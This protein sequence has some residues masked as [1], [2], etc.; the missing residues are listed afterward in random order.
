MRYR[1]VEY[2]FSVR[3]VNVRDGGGDFGHAFK[4]LHKTS[5]VTASFARYL[6]GHSLAFFT[7]P[8]QSPLVL[9]AQIISWSPRSR[10]H[11]QKSLHQQRRRHRPSQRP[12]PPSPARSQSHVVFDSPFFNFKV[13][14]NWSL[15]SSTSYR[16]DFS[17]LSG[18]DHRAVPGWMNANVWVCG[19][20]E[21]Y[22]RR[23]HSTSAAA[24]SQ[25]LE[26]NHG[27]GRG[28]YYMTYLDLTQGSELQT[29]GVF[30]L[31]RVFLGNTNIADHW[32]DLQRMTGQY[33]S[34]IIKNGERKAGG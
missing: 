2:D 27:L 16:P 4:T 14:S 17:S 13:R 3:H 33:H 26:S 21:Y 25:L 19:P 22:L 20:S 24:S 32:C 23:K 10:Q 15:L 9:A 8:V 31:D 1:V 18:D 12:R 30:Y 6:G 7:T 5:T 11:P 29:G 28:Y 34:A